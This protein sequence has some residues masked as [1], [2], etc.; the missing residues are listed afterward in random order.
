M[1]TN[2]L[3]GHLVLRE[4]NIKLDIA[5]TLVLFIILL[6]FIL[7]LFLIF[8]ARQKGFVT[9]P[10]HAFEMEEVDFEV[11]RFLSFTNKYI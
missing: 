11:L 10:S 7:L 5:D 4:L 2:L 3:A 6:Y 9:K 1:G 8:D